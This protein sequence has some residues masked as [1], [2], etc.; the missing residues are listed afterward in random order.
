MAGR[1]CCLLQPRPVAA[2]LHGGWG[3]TF[4]DTLQESRCPFI[5][6]QLPLKA[7]GSLSH[8]YYSDKDNRAV[9]EQVLIYQSVEWLLWQPSAGVHWCGRVWEG[10]DWQDTNGWEECRQGVMWPSAI[11]NHSPSHLMQRCTIIDERARA[12]FQFQQIFSSRYLGGAIILLEPRCQT[13]YLPSRDLFLMVLMS[14]AQRSSV[15]CRFFSLTA[16]PPSYSYFCS[17][18]SAD[19]WWT[20]ERHATKEGC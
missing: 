13:D 3:P 18:L 19:K 10:P 17:I 20:Y 9:C 16:N 5:S 4:R 7:H 1:D 12:P 6:N 2:W 14:S 15:C 8:S 11:R